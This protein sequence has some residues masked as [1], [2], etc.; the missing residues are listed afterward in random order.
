MNIDRHPKIIS[1]F[2]G[3]VLGVVSVILMGLSIFVVPDLRN[4][5]KEMAKNFLK[6]H[7]P[8]GS[9]RKIVGEAKNDVKLRPGATVIPAKFLE[10]PFPGNR[11]ESSNGTLSWIAPFSM[12]IR[13]D[14]TPPRS[15]IGKPGTS[16]ALRL[17]GLKGETLSFQIV[18][19]ANQSKTKKVRVVLAQDPSEMGSSCLVVHRFLEWYITFTSRATKYGPLRTITNPDPLIPFHDPYGTGTTLVS[20]VSVKEDSNQ[21]VWIDV[22]MSRN[23]QASVYHGILTLSTKGRIIRKTPVVFEVL[24]ATLPRTTSL[25]RWMELYNT[26]FWRGEMI[27]NEDEYRLLFQRDL[28]IDPD[29]L[30]GIFFH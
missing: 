16:R 4:H 17:V 2:T 26:R 5:L 29:N 8:I 19:R 22:K 7:H 9:L 25:Q 15:K 21:V 28:D 1:F 23:C 20:K 27:K 3:F 18:L 24:D 30:V 6:D 12:R 11:A 13:P 14:D 10:F